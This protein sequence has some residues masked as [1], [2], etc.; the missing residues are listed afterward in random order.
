MHKRVYSA[1]RSHRPRKQPRQEEAA[2]AAMAG[3]SNSSHSVPPLD[4]ESYFAAREQLQEAESQLA[5]DHRCRQQAT[6]LE[7][8]ADA[9]IHRLRRIDNERVY[10]SA[11]KR[12]GHAGQQHRRFAGDHFL[13]N[14]DLIPK[15]ALFDVARHIPK[16]AHLHIHFN[17]C[18][19]PE[20]L[21]GIAKTMERMFIMSSHPL[22]PDAGF[23]NY[24]QC[25]LQFSIMCQDREG[26][27]SGDIF[28]PDYQPWGAMRL[29]DF[30]RRFK[31]EN[32]EA[33]VDEWL[34]EKLVF[35]EDGAHGLLQTASG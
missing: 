3:Q 27:Q 6:A 8:K 22:L 11:A 34:I 14:L 25:E 16:G 32:S 26:Q 4:I 29:S 12:T 19:P 28:S 21:L 15:T 9:V 17:A 5:F 13:S 33:D 23:E 10:A 7:K 31:E 1:L 2:E 30:L 20:V 18:L 35:N 24:T